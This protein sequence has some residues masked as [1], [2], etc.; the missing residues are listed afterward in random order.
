MHVSILSLKI[1]LTCGLSDNMIA[2]SP[3]S[4]IHCLFIV[5]SIHIYSFNIYFSICFFV[6]Y[7]SLLFDFMCLFIGK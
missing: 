5:R 1:K 2:I 3:I 4:V 6:G 7:N